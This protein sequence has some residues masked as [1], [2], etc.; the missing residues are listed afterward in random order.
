MRFVRARRTNQRKPVEIAMGHCPAGG[1]RRFGASAE[2]GLKVRKGEPEKAAAFFAVA[3]EQLCG[4]PDAS[5]VKILDFGCG[6]GNLVERLL[7]RQYD[8]FGCDIR[9]RWGDDPIVEERRLK[10]IGQGPYAIPFGDGTFDA[11]ISTSVFEHVQ[12]KEESFREIHRVLRPGGYSMHLFPSKWY[13]PREP[14]NLVP[15]VNFFWPRCP[16][17]WL[18]L[19]ARL[20]VRGRFQQGMNWRQVVDSNADYFVNGTSYWPNSR[21]RK[22]SLRIFGNYSTPMRFYIDHA[23]GGVARLGRKLPFRRLSGW[24]TAQLRMIFIVQRK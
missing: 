4:F 8:A 9:A 12:N 1:P 2:K 24:M 23:F 19:W 10:V 13:L 7:A 21:Y 14:H 17:W 11:V 15:L 18:A 5:K 22:L 20:G 6:H 3:A 16:R